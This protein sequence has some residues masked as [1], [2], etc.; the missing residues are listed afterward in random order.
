MRK[1]IVTFLAAIILSVAGLAQARGIEAG[2]AEAGDFSIVMPQFP[3]LALTGQDGVKPAEYIPS[4]YQLLHILFSE[5]SYTIEDPDTKEKV[6]IWR[7]TTLSNFDTR[8]EATI[9]MNYWKGLIQSSGLTVTTNT[10]TNIYEG[11]SYGFNIYYSGEKY[12]EVYDPDT[13][14][15]SVAEAK[16]ALEAREALLRSA[17]LKVME[18]FV[19]RGGGA[20]MLVIYYHVDYVKKEADRL[21]AWRYSPLIL[22]ADEAAAEAQAAKDT[23][24]LESLAVPVLDTTVMSGPK[25]ALYVLHYIG[26]KGFI[27]SHTSETLA[28]E[29]A[30]EKALEAFINE[31]GSAVVLGSKIY[32]S[33]PWFKNGHSFRVRY[34]QRPL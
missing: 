1:S 24:A 6:K 33:G 19:A 29:A 16:A 9:M 15:P 3:T 31:L 32:P 21:K 13:V 11:G 22:H 2:R 28:S 5:P 25:G 18:G 23:A 20:Y 27:K 17:G 30:A 14:Y 4:Y 10:V 12:I 34:A 8:Q 7:I 26:R